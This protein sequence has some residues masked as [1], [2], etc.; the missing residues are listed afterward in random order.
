MAKAHVQF[1]VIVP[2]Y[3]NEPFL[4]RAIKSALTQSVKDGF[5]V[6]VVDDCSTDRTPKIVQALAAGHPNLKLL[7]TPRN[8]GPGPARDVAIEAAQ[9]EWIVFLDSDDFLHPDALSALKTKIA[10]SDFDAVGFDWAHDPTAEVLPH[11]QSPGRRDLTLLALDRRSLIDKYLALRMDGS[12]IYTAVKKRLLTE[13]KLKFAGGYHEDV[14]YIFKIYWHAKHI[15]QMKE[16]LYYKRVHKGSIVNRISADHVNG[17]LRA[18][19]EIG[20]Y[21]SKMSPNEWSGHLPHYRKGI[22][23]VIATRTREIVRRA[24]SADETASLFGL[25]HQT[26]KQTLSSVEPLTGTLD[27]TQYELIAARFAKVMGEKTDPAAKVKAITDYAAEISK[28]TWSCV[29]LH[30]SAFL[31]PD[32]VRTCCKRFFVDG[33]MRGDVVIFK[34]S[35]AAQVKDLAQGILKAKQDLLSKINADE[36]SACEQCP[37]LEF[38]EWGPLEKLDIKYLSCEYHSVCNLHCTY[39]SDLYYG[40]KKV[41][42]DIDSLLNGFLRDGALKS[43]G[44]VVWGGG[45]PLKDREF[46]R[47]LELLVNNVPNAEHRVLSNGVMFSPV[48]E[49]LLRDGRIA[50]TSSLDA[51]TVATY[52]LVRGQDKFIESLGTLQK[53]A[54]ANAERLTIK[55]IFTEDNGTL[56]EVKHFADRIKEYN[57]LGCNFQVSSNFKKDGIGEQAFLSMVVLYGL[58]VNEGARLVFL[59]D[60]VRQ[61]IGEVWPVPE[62]TV[63]KTLEKYG[64]GHTLADRHK[65]KSVAIWG[66]GWIAKHLVEKAAFFREVDVAFFVDNRPAMTGKKYLGKEIVLPETLRK[67]DVPIVIAAAQGYPIIYNTFLKMGLDKSRFIHALIL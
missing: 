24:S 3:N 14:D 65:Y 25:L 62:A 49:R 47:R 38:K 2:T 55:Y 7:R 35:Q 30:H 67:S 23:G 15:G 56:D 63:R 40:G 61:R 42:Y 41:Q 4:E 46:E 36:K 51:G 54:A 5:E 32:E 57:L 13:N 31:A 18:W 26:W 22:I 59:D 53:Y 27:R 66:A 1:S 12:V 52:K 20:D 8:S 11:A 60:L 50:M 48:L 43:C 45:E 17:F 29:D 44:T 10:E 33:E 28:K 64:L 37:F 16:V 6:L 21:A 19:K 58:L 39:C 9:G 34:S